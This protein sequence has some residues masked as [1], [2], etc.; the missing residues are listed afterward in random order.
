M[1]NMGQALLE[2]SLCFQYLKYLY[3]LLNR[4]VQYDHNCLDWSC[5]A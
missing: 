3:S 4:V 2:T 5:R 1:M